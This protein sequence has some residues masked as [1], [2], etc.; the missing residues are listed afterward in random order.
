MDLGCG[1]PPVDASHAAIPL[2]LVALAAVLSTCRGFRTS[3]VVCL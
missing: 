3:K 1:S 2:L